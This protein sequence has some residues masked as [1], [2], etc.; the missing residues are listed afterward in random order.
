M[1]PRYTGY[2]EDNV[3]TT[4]G[5]CNSRSA[6]LVSLWMTLL[7]H[8]PEDICCARV[9]GSHIAYRI[10]QLSVVLQSLTIKEAFWHD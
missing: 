4:R 8:H 2:A 1:S 9:Q 10:V 3:T 5:I 7:P 6:L